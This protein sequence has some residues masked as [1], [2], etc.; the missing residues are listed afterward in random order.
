M[1]VMREDLTEVTIDE[2]T[3]FGNAERASASYKTT[4]NAIL[5]HYKPSKQDRGQSHTDTQKSTQQRLLLS[6]PYLQPR[7]DPANS[8]KLVN[9][10]RAHFN[11]DTEIFEWAKRTTTRNL[12]DEE[13]AVYAR[14]FKSTRAVVSADLDADGREK[15]QR[16]PVAEG[17]K[18]DIIL[19]ARKQFRGARLHF[20]SASASSSDHIIDTKLLITFELLVSASQKLTRNRLLLAGLRTVVDE[21]LNGLDTLI[22]LRMSGGDLH[23]KTK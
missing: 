18:S 22:D 13:L 1:K 21:Q 9:R 11:A 7:D 4:L 23:E 6:M 12:G 8:A 15:E 19:E 17:H 2:S 14:N 5:K 10:F 20:K 3:G 16:I